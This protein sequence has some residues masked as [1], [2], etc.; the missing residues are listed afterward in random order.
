MAKGCQVFLAQISAK[1]EEDKSERKQIKD[2][3]IVRDFP[4]NYIPRTCPCLLQLI[5]VE[6]QIEPLIPG[7][8]RKL[9]HRIVWPHSEM[10]EVISNNYKELLTRDSK[11]LVPTPWEP[12]P[13]I[14]KRRTD[15]SR[16]PVFIRRR[17][18]IRISPSLEYENKDIPKKAFELVCKPNMENIVIVF[19]DDILIYS[20]DEKEH[21][22]HL[23]AILELLKKEQL[24]AKFSKCEFWIPKYDTLHAYHPETDGQSERTIQ[25][26]KDML[27]ACVIDFGKGWVKH[28][29]LAEFSYNN[30]YHASIKAAPYEALY[31][32]KCRSPVCWAEDRQ[33]SYADQKRKPIEFEI[34][35]RVCHKVLTLEM[36]V[37]IGKRGQA[38]PRFVDLSRNVTLE[39]LVMPLEG[40]AHTTT[41]VRKH[42][43]WK[44]P[45]KSGTG[46][47]MIV[48]KPATHWLRFAGTL[49]G[50]AE[51]TGNV[52]IPF[53]TKIPNNSSQT[54][55][56]YPLQD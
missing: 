29:P 34:G 21:E 1:K 26:L 9:E 52:K 36:G 32:Q 6:F 14:S 15:P 50:A 22:E 8:H 51:F 43:L 38:E 7:A 31:G 55:L 12:R 28:L 35:D 41:Q 17:P 25:T 5:P 33:K 42:H 45:L 37:R 53:K 3:P 44:S 40:I 11:G 4:K 20:R 16:I 24:Y 48:A 27:R 2:V 18:E 47:Q 30:S 46:D 10:K 39:P 54:G 56:T 13:Y 23:K 19:I 49:T